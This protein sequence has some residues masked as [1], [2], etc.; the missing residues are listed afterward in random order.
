MLRILQDLQEILLH[1]KWPFACSFLLF[2]ADFC[3]IPWSL[4][5][6][7]VQ[8]YEQLEE[9]RKLV[10]PHDT[11]S[12][13]HMG[14]NRS[15]CSWLQMHAALKKS[16]SLPQLCKDNF[17]GDIPTDSFRS[18]AKLAILLRLVQVCQH[19]IVRLL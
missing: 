3:P 4:L 16:D 12:V 10:R 8:L 1:D 17:P 5:G 15:N 2:H 18:R 19:V 14:H 9:R 6:H 11:H 7:R 13:Q